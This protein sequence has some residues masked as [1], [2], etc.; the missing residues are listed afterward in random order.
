MDFER[1][2]QADQPS[3]I[4]EPVAR[5]V[6]RIA[7]MIVDQPD[8]VVVC[9]LDEPEGTV[10]QLRVGPHDVGRVIGKKG[11]T[12]KAIRTIVAAAG[13]K[14]GRRLTLEVLD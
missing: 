7:G 8:H 4:P 1:N 14:Q 6:H 3:E 12:A 10:F 5:L 9:Q 11:A 13:Q 2:Q